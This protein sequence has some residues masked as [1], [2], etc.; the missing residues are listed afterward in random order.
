MKERGII[1]SAPMVKALLEGRK[2]VTRRIVH[3]TPEFHERARLLRLESDT[4]ARRCEA[5][6]GDSLPD[7][8]VPIRVRCP[9]GFVDRLWVREAFNVRGLAWGMP[10]KDG[11]KIASREAWRYAATDDGSWTHGWKSPI[12][13]PRAASR[14]LL[15]IVDV[16]VERLHD[17]TEKDAIA[18][19][20]ERSEAGTFYV[21]DNEVGLA[22]FASARTA[23]AFGWDGI[24]GRRAEWE[25]N[26]FV[27]RLELRRLP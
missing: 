9:Y 24:N 26:P 19:G 23:F 25:S 20:L 14:I 5:V 17:I 18:E 22:E 6:F 21:R 3:G 1:F 8:P 11:A 4:T 10:L 7:D 15:E 13:M 27:W 2:S 12:Y 16:R